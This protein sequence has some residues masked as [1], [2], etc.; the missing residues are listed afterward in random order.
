MLC[1]G[2]VSGVF[3]A[4]C[5]AQA[6]GAKARVHYERNLLPDVQ[7]RGR[8]A[9]IGV[10]LRQ[11]YTREN[12]RSTQPNPFH[13]LSTPVIASRSPNGRATDRRRLP[14]STRSA[15]FGARMLGGG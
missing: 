4:A 13:E 1:H 11:R 12:M 15:R 10:Y 3:R 14:L 9:R 7:L 6:D 8:G 2:D 5:P